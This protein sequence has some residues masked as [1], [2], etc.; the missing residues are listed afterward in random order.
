MAT[1]LSCRIFVVAPASSARF[2]LSCAALLLV[3]VLVLTVSAGPA[4]ASHPEYDADDFRHWRIT[5]DD[6]EVWESK[7]DATLGEWFWEPV[8]P[9]PPDYVAFQRVLVPAPNTVADYHV[10]LSRLELLGGDLLTGSDAA[11]R[12]HTGSSYA[13]LTLAPGEIAVHSELLKWNGS[14]WISARTSGWVYSPTAGSSFTPT[15]RWGRAPAGAGYYQNRAHVAHVA[16]VPSADGGTQRSWSVCGPVY[17]GYLYAGAAGA[18]MSAMA[19]TGE[20]SWPVTPQAANGSSP[21]AE[22]D[23][24]GKPLPQL[25]S[26]SGSV[27]GRSKGGC[28]RASQR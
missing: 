3:L 24:S 22:G 26:L 5:T 9:L 7:W 14:S 17:S 21:A 18:T 1:R 19:S 12:V 16:E 4:L 27:K 8:P 10:V 13:R 11:I 2:C 23:D 15:F 28:S 6:G 25:S 20:S